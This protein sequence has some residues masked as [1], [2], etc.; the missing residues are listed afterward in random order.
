MYCFLSYPT[1]PVD[2][3]VIAVPPTDMLEVVPGLPVMF[4]IMAMTDAGT[5]SYQWQRNEVDIAPT[6][7]VSGVNTRTLTITNVQESNEGM[8]RCVVTNDAGSTNS[9]TSQLTVCKYMC[10]HVL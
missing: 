6:S 8:Y 5:L 7:G 1:H 9:N 4:S 3:P 2:R 10:L